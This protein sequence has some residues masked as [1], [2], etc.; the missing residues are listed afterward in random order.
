MVNFRVKG[1]GGRGGVQKSCQYTEYIYLFQPLNLYIPPQKYQPPP[2]KIAFSRTSRV[3]IETDEYNLINQS[4]E[5]NLL[6]TDNT[7]R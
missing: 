2:H 5:Y 1:G 6:S 4:I 7:Y 3:S